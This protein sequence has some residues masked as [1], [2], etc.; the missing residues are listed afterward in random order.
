MVA[1]K[2]PDAECK[3]VTLKIDRRTV[4]VKQGTTILEAAKS[5]GLR[6]PTLCYLKGINEIG[7]CRVCV[8]ELK[9]SAKLVTAC[10]T[11][12]QEGMEVLTSS[13]RVRHARRVTVE[14]M[15]TEHNCNCPTCA[16]NGNCR[17]QT[18]ANALG[19]RNVRLGN[20][21]TGQRKEESSP[22]I[23]RDPQK[24]I[25]C[26]RCVSLCD[27]VQTLGIWRIGGTGARTSIEPP[28]GRSLAQTD[29]A[30]C[31]QCVTHCPVGA[32]TE[33]I[34]R[35]RVW[36]ALSDPETVTIVQVAPAVR[37]AWGETLGMPRE[38]ATLKRLVATLR[39][40]GFDYVLDTCFA[41]DLTIME[42]GTELLQRLSG[43]NVKGDQRFPM[44]TSC[45]P[46]WI[47]FLKGQYPELVGNLSS[48]KSP[49]Q[50]FGA[51]AK[52]YYSQVMGIPAE[53]ICVVS[54]MPCTAKKY[55]A[56]L[57]TMRSAGF[58]QDVDIVITTRELCAM[59]REEG[60]LPERLEEEE[61]DSILGDSTGAAVIFGATGGV[62]E[63]ALRSAY[64]LVTGKNAD[65]DAFKAVRGPDGWKEASFELPG[66][67]LKCAVVH[68][69]GNA[70]RLIEALKDGTHQYDFVEV[71]ACPG[72]CAGGG[73]QPICSD[74][75]D[76]SP[77]RT[78]NLYALDAAAPLRFSHENP[79][80][81][82]LY[83]DF[84]GRPGSELA[85]KL[86]HTDQK[87]WKMNEGSVKASETKRAPAL[88]VSAV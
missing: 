71:M 7:A 83:Q 88:A 35:D 33:K 46:G 58:G 12:V 25:L 77:A 44:F 3:M 85:H 60:V 31:G 15:L 76:V 41:A 48:A 81:K 6:I 69:L 55:E 45:C 62:M 56:N 61:F 47:R 10:N 20:V 49:Q 68:G 11:V 4:E 22:S 18:L 53:K 21:L 27:K 36:E 59:I 13:P 14:L 30:Y 65:P 51:I 23:V 43:E 29:C 39:H 86:L 42:E 57:D 38:T 67:T 40:L 50:M 66:R 16:R 74:D 79:S 28:F 2:I 70:R 64:Y 17:L 82:T 8:V 34:D 1:N 52:T 5:I 24:C 26:Y 80:I 72:G 75:N 63:A 73:G 19:V 84:L 54:I 87:E 37:A 9:G 78:Q 32:L